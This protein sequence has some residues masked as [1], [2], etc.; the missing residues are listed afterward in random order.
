MTAT[1]H[2]RKAKSRQRRLLV[3]PLAALVARS[4]T[5]CA[6]RAKAAV[7][8]ALVTGAEARSTVLS[9]T[10]EATIV[11]IRRCTLLRWRTTF[12]TIC[13]AC[14]ADPAPFKINPHRLIPR[15][16]I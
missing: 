8:P 4:A 14:R 2:D 6:G 7:P 1:A 11:E 13:D 12:Q 10:E 5:V 16:D 15:P 3:G 9:K